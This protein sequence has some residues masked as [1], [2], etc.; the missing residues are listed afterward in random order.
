MGEALRDTIRKVDYFAMKARNQPGEAARL[1]EIF[2]KAGVNLLGFTG[3]PDG[4]GAQ[5]DFIPE[6]PLQFS[7]AAEKAGLTFQAQKTGF[8]I[9]GS[10]RVGAVADVIGRLAAARI[11]I[12]AVDAVCAGGGR[13]G[14]MLWV[15]A[16]DVNK[17]AK[18]LGLS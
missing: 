6:D 16:P 10:D 11:N 1:L 17:A 7:K 14:A 8:L 2:R 5:I 9:Q 12:T 13:Y 18:E 3:F 15:K 4:P